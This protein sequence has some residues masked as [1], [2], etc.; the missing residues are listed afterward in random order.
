MQAEALEKHPSRLALLAPQDEDGVGWAKRLVRRKL[1]R[2]KAEA[3]PRTAQKFGERVGSAL[4]DLAHPTLATLA[5]GAA[6]AK[7]AR[8][9][10]ALIF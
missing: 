10:V 9:D 2:A 1:N 7:R 8:V 6:K 4:R 5:R 3:C